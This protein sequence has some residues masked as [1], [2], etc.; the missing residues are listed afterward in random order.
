[1]TLKWNE[2]RPRQVYWIQ[3]P[4]SEGG[5]LLVF[6]SGHAHGTLH[7]YAYKE[8]I[9]KFDKLWPKLKEL[10]GGREPDP[11]CRKESEE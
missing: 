4:E 11:L 7:V 6:D 5:H 2:K 9:S 8:T 10:S 3:R 1:M